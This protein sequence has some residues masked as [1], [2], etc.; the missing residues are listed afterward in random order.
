MEYNNTLMIINII[1]DFKGK[2][3]KIWIEFANS[4]ERFF[5][6]TICLNKMVKKKI[7]K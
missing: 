7:N 5:F 2:A 4:Y 1:C 6:H 3:K